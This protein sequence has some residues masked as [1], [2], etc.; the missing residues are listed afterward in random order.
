MGATPYERRG[1]GGQ[2]EGLQAELFG[3]LGCEADS[4]QVFKCQGVPRSLETVPLDQLWSGLR[5]CYPILLDR[6]YR[7]QLGHS[8]VHPDD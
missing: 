7:S 1:P 6:P 4:G 8:V 5:A 3:I 2:L